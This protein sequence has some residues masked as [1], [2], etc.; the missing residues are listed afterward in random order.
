MYEAFEAGRCEEDPA[1]NWYEN[2]LKWFNTVV[3]PLARKLAN[4]GIFGNGGDEFLEAAISN[5]DEWE[6]KGREVVN[7]Y[8]QHYK[9]LRAHQ[10]V[11]TFEKS[12]HT[13]MNDSQEASVDHNTEASRRSHQSGQP[14][15][16]FADG[17]M[18]VE[19]TPSAASIN[20]DTDEEG[21]QCDPDVVYAVLENDADPYAFESYT[22]LTPKM[23]R[24]QEQKRNARSSMISRAS[25]LT[26]ASG[27]ERLKRYFRRQYST[28]GSNSGVSKAS[29]GLSSQ[30]VDSYQSYESEDT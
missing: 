4:S 2:E 22:L 21:S 16:D 11:D 26:R 25:M 8:V 10:I 3:I 1:I 20:S 28:A 9:E 27:D 13:G 19:T 17:V 6:S 18:S 23:R 5:R 12:A 7:I 30:S 24:K 29:K 15:V 14:S